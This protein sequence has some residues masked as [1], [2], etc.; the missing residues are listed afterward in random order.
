MVEPRIFLCRFTLFNAA[1]SAALKSCRL[2]HTTLE[3]EE[4]LFRMWAPK[5]LSPARP[6]RLKITLQVYYNKEIVVCQ[7]K[8]VVPYVHSH[9]KVR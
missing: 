6:N 5:L 7:I 9:Y 1:E 8:K 2:Q 4:I 3:A